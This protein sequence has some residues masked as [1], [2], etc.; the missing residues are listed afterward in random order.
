MQVLASGCTSSLDIISPKNSILVHLKYFFLDLASCFLDVLS[1]FP[2]S[3][4][5]HCLLLSASYPTVIMS[6]VIQKTVGRSL[7][8]SPIFHWN[9]PP[10]D[11]TTNG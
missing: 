3:G 7:N 10:A 2:A 8:I 4:F 9:K 6:C 1:A 11:A 5:C